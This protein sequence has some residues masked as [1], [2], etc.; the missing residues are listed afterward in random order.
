MLGFYASVLSEKVSGEIRAIC[1]RCSAKKIRLGKI[2][3]LSPYCEKLLQE[4]R[5]FL[6]DS[7][8]CSFGILVLFIL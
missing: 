3:G 5:H 8:H 7:W 2:K 6:E 4:R 1:F